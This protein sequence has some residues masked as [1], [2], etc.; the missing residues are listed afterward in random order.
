MDEYEIRKLLASVRAGKTGVERAV[1][2]LRKLPFEDLGF[3][4]IDHHRSLRVGYS[5]VVYARG[6]TPQQV[7]RIVRGMM[8]SSKRQN[9]L[10]TRASRPV[11][12][13]VRKLARG[14]RFFP[15]SGAIAIE[16]NR[17]KPG[18]GLILIVT[19]GTSDIPVAEEAWVTARLWET[20]PRCYVT[21]ASR[22]CTD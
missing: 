10:V 6:K 21:S 16:R 14:A 17:D 7:A 19:A 22:G 5:E 13:A 3:A 15:L 12:T 20:T 8:R 11:F 2:R 18:K 9:I 1:V 4:K